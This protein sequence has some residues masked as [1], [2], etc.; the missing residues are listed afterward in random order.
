MTSLLKKIKQFFTLYKKP[1]LPYLETHLTDHCN[2]NCKAC[3][4][5]CPISE[6][7]YW[8]V[9]Q[10]ECSLKEI[11]TKFTIEKLRL[12]GGE[13]LLHP[14]VIKF[15]KKSREILPKT[16]IRIVS[17]GILIK[18]MPDEFWTECKNNNITIDI[19]QYPP[20]QEKIPCIIEYI[21]Q[22]GC[23]V[24]F[25]NPISKFWLTLNKDGS[26]DIKQAFDDC[27]EF[28]NCLTL[29][30]QK[31]YKCPIGAYIHKYNNHFQESIPEE[32]GISTEK[33]A[34]EIV[35]YINV[36]MET[37]RYCSMPEN[38]WDN[39]YWEVSKKEK[40]EWFIKQ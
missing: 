33:T 22:K 29:Y 11:A 34:K 35:N 39:C 40:D 18:T 30:N 38:K 2:L 26:S 5:F 1:V 28:R 16:D 20:M 25:I 36:P 4:H 32:P 37:C 13:P 10:F 7:K 31:I 23:K 6:E 14:D 27:Q 8:D 17:N 21:E 3:N 24:G 19:S 12:L 9:E 15:I